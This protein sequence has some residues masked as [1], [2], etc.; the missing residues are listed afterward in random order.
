MSNFTDIEDENLVKLHAFYK[1]NKNKIIDIYDKEKLVYKKGILHITLQ[2]NEVKL[3]YVPEDKLN[4]SMQTKLNENYQENI[5][6]I[7]IFTNENGIVLEDT[8]D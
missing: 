4:P 8:I 2:N 5:Y 1:N 6:Y 3:Y 7:Y